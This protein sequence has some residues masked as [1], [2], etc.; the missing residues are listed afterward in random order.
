MVTLGLVTILLGLRGF[1]RYH[2]AIGAPFGFWDNLY[3]SLQLF[4]LGS[5]IVD[6]PEYMTWELQIARFLAPAVAMYAVIQALLVIFRGQVELF[7][8]HRMRNHAIICGLG[9]KGSLLVQEFRRQGLSVVGIEKNDTLAEISACRAAGAIVI[10]GDMRD[11]LVLRKAGV[12]RARYLVA[13]SGD[14]GANAEVAVQARRMVNNNKTRELNCSIH[15]VDMQ[16]W[17]VLREK[18][19]AADHNPNFRLEFFNVYDSAARIVLR[20]VPVL[21]KQI[22]W[23]HHTPDD[24][25]NT[26]PRLLIVGM[27]WFPESLLIHA[28]QEWVPN[29]RRCGHKLPILIID[30]EAEKKADAL[31]TRVPLISAVCDIEARSI[32]VEGSDFYKGDFLFDDRQRRRLTHMYVCQEDSSTAISTGLELL[33]RVRGNHVQILVRMNEDSGLATLLRNIKSGDFTNLTTFGLL[34][35]TCKP[36]LFDDGTHETLARVIHAAY[37]ESQAALGVTPDKNRSMLPWELLPDP[38][39]QSNREQADDIGVK[40]NA[41]GY[42]I[43]PWREFGAENFQFSQAEIEKLAQMEHERWCR[44]RLAQGWR[45]GLQR[46]NQQKIH[47]DLV[48][49][50][51]LDETERE[52]NRQAAR[53]IPVYLI[54]AGFQLYPLDT[55]N[56]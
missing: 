47:P 37:T 23:A 29:F 48:D 17:T 50:E 39:R 31:C 44:G 9:R 36:G 2:A 16:L 6:Q 38:L 43:A 14:D 25:P 21:D 51:D 20:E 55:K 34:E 12:E 10:T 41:L 26:L 40:V 35:R 27:G 24:L 8:L 56:G 52:K 7:N 33:R 15:I 4:G 22:D 28:A 5:G 30:D 19:L 42:G 49:W 18:E 1:S 11:T 13:V 46:D 54:K 32:G 45:F 3:L 53:H